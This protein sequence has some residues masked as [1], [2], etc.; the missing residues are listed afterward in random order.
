MNSTLDQLI[1]LLKQET[2]LYRS[3]LVVINQEKKAAVRSDVNALNETGIEKEKILLELQKKEAQRRQLVAGLA[4][5]LGYAV[6][7]L[8]LSQISQLVDE[9]LAGSL[10]LVSKDLLSVLS[11]LQ[12]ANQRNQ[13]IFEHS[14]ELLR[15]SF[16]MLNELLT[17]NTVYYRTGN[18]QST[19]STGKCVCSDI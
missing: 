19:K 17:P 8:T 16:N 1:A 14:L 13:Q 10:R 3:L 12:T 9:P 7:D 4:E 18:I 6:Q 5:T 2:G 11:Q 15:G